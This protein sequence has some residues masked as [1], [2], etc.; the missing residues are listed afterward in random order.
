[1]KAPSDPTV[2]VA[3]KIAETI[4][5]LG[6]L[7]LHSRN[8]PQY[9]QA[10]PDSSIIVMGNGPSLRQTIDN[11]MSRLRGT[12]TL[13]V[14]FAA[15]TP[16][17]KL[18]KPKYYV[19]ADPVFFQNN[20]DGQVSVLWDNLSSISWEMNLFVPTDKNV[21]INNSNLNVFP[22]NMVG[23]EGCNALTDYAY[24]HRLG[25]PRPRNVLIPSLM[26]ACWLGYKKISIVG[27]DHSWSETLRVD[28]EN[29]VISI[30]PH[31]YSDSKE[32]QKR[33]A[34]VYSDV[35]LHHIIYSFYI[36]FRAYH[37]IRRFADRNGI[38]IINE[39]PDSFIDAFERHA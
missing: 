10:A 31:F 29:R 21:R 13:A 35:R 12:D 3:G 15:N 22:F 2:T 25:M 11:E 27:A 14:N 26:I 32:E 8:I 24:N 4:T 6:K 39:T 5:S 36:A 23:I 34:Q 38:R 19:L 1:M 33:V 16:E 30:Q 9:P 28:S 37:S 18:I 7:L 17:F 20:P